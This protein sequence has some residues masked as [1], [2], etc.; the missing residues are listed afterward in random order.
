[1]EAHMLRTCP[2]LMHLWTTASYS[3]QKKQ[4]KETEQALQKIERLGEQVQNNGQNQR[5]GGRRVACNCP[6]SLGFL[7]PQ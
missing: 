7:S 5:R 1:M 3:L 2:T 4:T 6:T